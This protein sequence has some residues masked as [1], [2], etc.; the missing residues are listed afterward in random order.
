MDMT[1][2]DSSK[3]TVAWNL[4]QQSMFDSFANW[5]DYVLLGLYDDRLSVARVV[6]LA[7]TGIPLSSECTGAFASRNLQTATPEQRH[8]L[9]REVFPVE[10]KFV[11]R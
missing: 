4:P 3:T 2:S 9:I 1:A 10:E 11:P 7:K 5:L 8:S 6:I